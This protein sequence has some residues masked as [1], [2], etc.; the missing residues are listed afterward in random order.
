MELMNVI[1]PVIAIGGLGLLFGVGLGIAAKKFAVPTDERVGLVKSFLPGANC[2]GCG[3]AGC[4]AFAKAVVAGEAKVN[5]CPVCNDEQTSGIAS[6]MGQKVSGGIKNK[7]FIKC[8]GTLENAPEKYR[9]SGVENCQSAQLVGGGPKKC[10]YGCL[11]FGSCQKACA[12]DAIRI[13]DGL[14]TVDYKKCTGCGSCMNACPRQLIALEPEN[15]GYTVTCSSKDKGKEVKESCKIGCIGCGIC[16]KQCEAEA[17]V[18]TN[19]V[20]IIDPAKC[21]QCG[22]CEKK[23]PT[24]A[25]LALQKS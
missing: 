14:A 18:V 17:I 15:M 20:A 5:G 8:R 21:T 13:V 19:N 1:S 7:A 6:V 4:E 16:V 24:H 2:G 9:Y 11:G 25:I 3:F 12:F 22:K 10:Q 23:C